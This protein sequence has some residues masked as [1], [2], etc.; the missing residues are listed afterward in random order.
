[1]QDVA[2]KEPTDLTRLNPGEKRAR[3]IADLLSGATVSSV[4]ARYGLHRNTVS[5]WRAGIDPELT[6]KFREDVVADLS[7]LVVRHLQQQFTAQEA[8]LAQT[9]D[10]EWLKSQSARD[11]AVFFGVISD[12]Q[13]R[14]LEAATP[15][16]S[17]IEEATD[18][19]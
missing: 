15:A 11:L 3:A 6:P 7:K 5:R 12:K 17:E 1:M 18:A 16:Y 4:A 19:S 10:A 2:L 9:A 8:I 14:I 13:V